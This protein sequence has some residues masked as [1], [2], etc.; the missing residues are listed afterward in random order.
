MHRTSKKRRAR[1]AIVTV[2]AA[3]GLSGTLVL[4]HALDNTAEH[5]DVALAATVFGIGGRGDPDSARVQDKLNGEIGPGFTTPPSFDPPGYI[6]IHYPASFNF[7]KSTN[8][9]VTT[10][11]PL[12]TNTP[13]PIQISAYSEGTLVAEQVKRDLAAAG[14]PGD[15]LDDQPDPDKVT[16]LLIA[17]PYVPNGGLFGRHPGFG[18]PGIVP[19]FSPAE[20]TAYDSTYVTNEYD[21]YADAPAYLNPAS[22]VNS[23]MAIKYAH[24]DQYYDDIDPNA[25]HGVYTTIVEDNGAGGTD[26]YIL[27]YNPELPLFGPV[28]QLEDNAPQL[29]PFLEPIVSSMEPVFRVMVD[30]GYT[31]R[32][33][34][35]PATPT[36]YSLITPP[37]K[38]KEALRQIPGAL[39]Q[40]RENFKAGH[41]V[42]PIPDSVTKTMD[43]PQDPNASLNKSAL[44]PVSPPAP[45]VPKPTPKARNNDLDK[46]VNR[47]THPT[48]RSDGSKASPGTKTPAAGFGH[49]PGANLLKSVTGGASTSTAP[50][51]SGGPEAPKTHHK[52]DGH[53]PKPGAAA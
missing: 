35:N 24:P 21:P 10:L 32:T 15:T 31:D 14:Y 49:G 38:I 52:R 19:T 30:M 25:D 6:A 44:A 1:K 16:F 23:L 18:I 4:G 40:G 33:N 20:P 42:T 50:S 48:V 53:T 7:Q 51:T 45:N 17:S 36:P 11:E 28:R 37:E 12:V 26:T 8:E 34:E 9:G 39:A 43:S 3:A 46:L 47:I 41:D 5:L 13:G 29:K 2:A 22:A 27:V